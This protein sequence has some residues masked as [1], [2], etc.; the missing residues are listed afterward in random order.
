MIHAAVVLVPLTAGVVLLAAVLQRFRRWAGWL[1][2]ALAAGSVV[3]TRL[4]TDSGSIL[5]RQ[6]AASGK[7][8]PLVARHQELGEQ[9]IWWVLGVLVVALATYGLGRR[10]RARD[11]TDRPAPLPRWLTAVVAVAAVLGAVGTV[12][13]TVRVGHSGAESVWNDRT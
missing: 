10:E 6:Q 5:Q 13:Q 1:P 2:L 3:L 12:V 7:L 4:A 9:L 8:D 11:R